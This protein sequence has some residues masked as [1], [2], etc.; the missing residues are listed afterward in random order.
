MKVLQIRSWAI[1]AVVVVPA[2]STDDTRMEMSTTQAADSMLQVEVRID[3]VAEDLVP[4]GLMLVAADG[5]MIVTQQ[6]DAAIRFFDIDG[7][8]MGSFG[9]S[10]EGPGEFRS[11]ARIGW[12][13]DTLWAFDSQLARFTLISADRWLVR[14]ILA[15]MQARP[16]LA[17][18]GRIPEF[19]IAIPIGMLPDGGYHA[20]LSIAINQDVPERFR[21]ASV[22][23]V[24]T[25]DG[26]VDRIIAFVASDPDCCI[27]AD[28][29]RGTSTASVP[30]TN[31]SRYVPSSDGKLGVRAAEVPADDGAAIAVTVFT[32]DGDTVFATQYPVTRVA[33]APSVR[34]SISRS[35]I[36]QLE[37]AS[38]D[39]ADAFRRQARIPEFYPAIANLLVG[40]DGSVWIEEPTADEN[41]LYLALSPTGEPLGRLRLPGHSRIAVAEQSRIWVLERDHDDVQSVVRY[42]VRW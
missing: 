8:S 10:G 36:A 24:I 31:R 27:R 39:L 42:R 32:T 41:R 6:Q 15:P 13:H 23:G 3:G 22:Y 9:R 25:E 33:I 30:F 2:C 29:P 18:S 7:E 4:I 20:Y 16:A 38:P 14:S 40:R 35:R 21:N 12:Y 37:Q 5:T 34:D 1:A 17:D 28:G 26:V 11:L 19:P